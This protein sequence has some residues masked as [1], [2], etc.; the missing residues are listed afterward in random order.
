[1]HAICEPHG[2]TFQLGRFTIVI[3]RGVPLPVRKA[4]WRPLPAPCKYF[5]PRR[6]QWSL[7]P[8][9]RRAL[10]AH[11]DSNG[12]ADALAFRDYIEFVS[13]CGLRVE[14][15]MALTTR[16]VVLDSKRPRI[17]LPAPGGVGTVCLPL[18]AAAA[19][20]LSR[21]A[22]AVREAVARGELAAGE[23]RF[24]PR[25]IRWAG[26]RWRA[27]RVMIGATREPTATLKALR[28][29]AAAYLHLELGMSLAQTSRYL[30]HRHV[31]TTREYL[32][33]TG[34][35]SDRAEHIS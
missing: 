14:E 33:V 28:R 16:D 13:L 4:A 30:R 15:A 24:W 19:G 34:G 35:H 29:S 3:E 10:L 20:I 5:Q 9:R 27:C 23:G 26:D 7:S 25:P 6:L 17:S 21:R 22:R 1:M 8:P 18:P 2:A 12:S 32:R 11:L 31:E